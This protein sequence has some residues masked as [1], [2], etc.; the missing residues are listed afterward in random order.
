MSKENHLM[1][2]CNNQLITGFASFPKK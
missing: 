1:S 2:G